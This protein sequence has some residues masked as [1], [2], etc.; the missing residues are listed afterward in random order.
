MYSDSEYYVEQSSS[1]FQNV[2]DRQIPTPSTDVHV[3]AL[4]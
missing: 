1:T 4:H 2:T 3:D